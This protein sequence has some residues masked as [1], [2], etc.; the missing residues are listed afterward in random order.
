[1]SL[2]PY[3]A[4]GKTLAVNVR[5]WTNGRED[6]VPKDSWSA[7]IWIERGED[8]YGIPRTGTVRIIQRADWLKAVRNADRQENQ[9]TKGR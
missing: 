2:A 7:E 9:N 5:T 6:D 3:T 1:M 8:E 4:F